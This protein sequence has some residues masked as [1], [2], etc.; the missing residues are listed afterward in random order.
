MVD[1]TQQYIRD[2][3]ATW[4]IFNDCYAIFDLGE[5]FNSLKTGECLMLPIISLVIENE[6]E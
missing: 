6:D 4:A 1:D 2:R 3:K 5:K